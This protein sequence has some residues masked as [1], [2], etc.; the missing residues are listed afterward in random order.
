VTWSLLLQDDPQDP[1]ETMRWGRTQT[2]TAPKPVSRRQQRASFGTAA[3]DLPRQ[4]QTRAEDTAETWPRSQLAQHGTTS[5]QTP[6]QPTQEP[7][8]L[9]LNVALDIA[10]ENQPQHSQPNGQLHCKT[11]HYQLPT[12]EHDDTDNSM[13]SDALLGRQRLAQTQHGR[14]SRRS[15]HRQAKVS[16]LEP[17]KAYLQMDE[18]NGK[19][20][21]Y[22]GGYQTPQKRQRIR[23][24]DSPVQINR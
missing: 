3:I 7:F 17:N 8:N 23:I 16:A 10:V 18:S 22:S 5:P 6:L 12:S 11:V 9:P 15:F 24:E 20:I 2:R 14:T 1:P 21:T 4:Q 13:C 19:N